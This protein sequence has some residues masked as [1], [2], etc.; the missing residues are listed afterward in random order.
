MARQ[1]LQ[2]RSASCHP[3]SSRIGVTVTRVELGGHLSRSSHNGLE[4]AADQQRL[5]RRA[6]RAERA[7]N[8]KATE[9][10]PCL[11]EPSQ[12]LVIRLPR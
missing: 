12:R 3:S 4:F 7:E 10:Q 1:P 2:A 11:P 9:V 8:Q 6:E 5:R